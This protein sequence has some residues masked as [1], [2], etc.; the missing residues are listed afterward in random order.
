[1]NPGAHDNHALTER[2]GSEKSAL[3]L[4]SGQ[5][6]YRGD[7]AL[8]YAFVVTNPLGSPKPKLDERFAL[9][10]PVEDYFQLAHYILSA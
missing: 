1:M 7:S 6:A 9:L 4:E 8:P 5:L 2:I 10:S 3:R